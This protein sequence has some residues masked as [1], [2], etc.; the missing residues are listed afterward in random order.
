MRRLGAAALLLAALWP[1]PPAQA[2]QVEQVQRADPAPQDTAEAPGFLRERLSRIESRLDAL[3]GRETAPTGAL[4]QPEA[5]IT[6]DATVPVPTET[7]DAVPSSGLRA[8]LDAIDSRLEALS[9]LL[10]G[11]RETPGNGVAVAAPA[12]P[13]APPAPLGQ[14]PAG[15]SNGPLDLTRETIAPVDRGERRAP[16]LS[17]QPRLPVPP[18]DVPSNA[19]P[20]AQAATQVPPP[21]APAEPVTALSAVPPAADVLR[22]AIADLPPRDLYDRAYR[23]VLAGDY[24]AAEMDFVQFLAVHPTNE[25]AG[26]A[27]F[28][29]GESLA[30]QGRHGE[31]ARHFLTVSQEDP[32]GPKAAESLL[33]LGLSLD[34]MGE[35][36]AACSS[37]RE[38]HARYP[39]IAD[40]IADRARQAVQDIGC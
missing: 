4:T 10:R 29:L 26:N 12:G 33:K 37:L 17:S 40:D 34:A 39:D 15:A 16:L 11:L 20:S 7:T 9:D 5:A 21:S 1:M 6:G 24:G 25:F 38:V 28:W 23:H 2:Q 31:A 19:V 13:G 36:Q 18:A 14:L 8:R 3:L 27:T 22:P 30:R 32:D 35:T